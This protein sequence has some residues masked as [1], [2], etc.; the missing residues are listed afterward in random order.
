LGRSS[1]R[2]GGRSYLLRLAHLHQAQEDGGDGFGEAGE[3]A[4]VDLCA[5]FAGQHLTVTE[6]TLTANQR[7]S[8]LSR[9]RFAADE[10]RGLSA[11]VDR[12]LAKG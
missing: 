1:H 11:Q 9:R 10:V 8:D 3:R 2:S 7:L 4:A 12:V 6:M 5:L